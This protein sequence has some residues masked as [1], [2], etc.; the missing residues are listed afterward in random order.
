[1]NIDRT[2]KRCFVISP[3]GEEGSDVRKHADD[4]FEYL[5]E[6][7]MKECGMSAI[8]SDHLDKPGRITDQM[9]RSIFESDLCMAVLTGYNPNVFY[10]LAV[11]QSAKRPVIILIEK[12][13]TLPFDIKDLRCIQYDLGIRSYNERTHIKRLVTFINDF[14]SNAWVAEDLF[15]SYR[16][17]TMHEPQDL[18]FFETSGEYGRESEWLQLM[19][20]TKDCFDILGMSLGAWRKTKDFAKLALAKAEKGCKI[21][22]LM[23]N[24]ANEI[25]RSLLYSE[26]TYT[27]DSVLNSIEDNLAFYAGLAK[28]NPSIEIR[29]LYRGIPHFFLTRTDKCAVLIQYLSSET[30]GAGPLWRCM[31]SSKLYNVAKNEFETLWKAGSPPDS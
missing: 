18:Q 11:A 9:F 17:P 31:T 5:I 28:K 30:W 3:I 19:N 20:E 29:S 27:L 15:S 25:L 22:V 12:S 1:M 23:M 10:E 16:A 13:H 8:R 26:T 24:G 21:R 6:P 2:S 4:V 14:S 7:A